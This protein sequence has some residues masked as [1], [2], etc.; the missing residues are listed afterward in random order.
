MTIQY[1]SKGIITQNLIEIIEERENNLK[2]ILGLDFKIDKTTPIGNMELADA[3]NELAIQELIAWLF[4]AQMDATTAE[5]IFLDAICE[6]N[7]IKII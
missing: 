1:D 5:G 2:P 4:P 3:N 7:R 6:K